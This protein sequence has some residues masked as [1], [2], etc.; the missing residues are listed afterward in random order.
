MATGKKIT[1]E[2]KHKNPTETKDRPVVEACSPYREIERYEMPAI[3]AR[4]MLYICCAILV[5]SLLWSAVA[6]VDVVAIAGGQTVPRTKVRPIQPESDGVVDALLVKEG[7]R[8][9]SGQ[10]L[11]L[12]DLTT[13][14]NDLDLKRRDLEIAVNQLNQL[15]CAKSALIQIVADPAK[16]PAQGMDVSNVGSLISRLHSAYVLS[17]EAVSDASASP[18]DITSESAQL[19]S[20]A[21]NLAA[22]RT[23]EERIKRERANEANSRLMQNKLEVE[24]LKKLLKAAQEEVVHLQSILDKTEAEESAFKMLAGQGAVSRVEHFRIQKEVSKARQEIIKQQAAIADLQKKVEIAVSAE[25]QL[26][27]EGLRAQSEQDAKARRILASLNQVNIQLRAAKRHHSV[28]MGEYYA[29]LSAAKAALARIETDEK[30]GQTRVKQ[31]QSAVDLATHNLEAAELKSPVDGL[32]T[33]IAIKGKGQVVRRGEALMSVVPALTDMLVECD[34]V[35][36]D[37]GFV[38]VGQ[39]AKLKLTAFPFEDF[40]VVP[41]RVIE[42]AKESRSDPKLGLVYKTTIEPERQWIKA[43]GRKVS[44]ASGMGVTCEIVT[45]R[46]SVLSLIMEPVKRLKE[47]R[48]N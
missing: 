7:E 38:E 21:A 31:C 12:L 18:E 6:Q 22:E 9:V 48:W 15:S 4:F 40:G 46:R 16:L 1:A 27:A 26:K 23:T 2:I 37:I 32:V 25:Y 39:K 33:N 29:A 45:R 11:L 10:K 3:V 30:Q 44:F 43:R 14:T 17:R 5:L 36:K 24:S 20:Q 8:V 28:S 41:G 34:V 42:V 19:R 35:S 13:Y 47:T